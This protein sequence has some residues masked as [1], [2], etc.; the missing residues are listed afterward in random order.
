MKKLLFILGGIILV[1]LLGRF[2]WGYYQVKSNATAINEPSTSVVA[3]NI[4]PNTTYNNL[5]EY[6]KTLVQRYLK[7]YPEFSTGIAYDTPGEKPEDHLMVKYYDEKTALLGEVGFKGMTLSIYDINTLEK[8]SKNVFYR[9]Y[10]DFKEYIFHVSNDNISYY[11]K[12]ATDF[13]L[14]PNSSLVSKKE[15]YISTSGASG[16]EG[17][18]IFDEITKTLTVSVFDPAFTNNGVSTKKIR[19]VKFIL[20]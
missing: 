7:K 15:T 2:G 18:I 13:Y 17:D 4:L 10:V 6:E 9:N 8:I 12:G 5:T 16:E 3:E 14:I 20:N 19:T 1:T 11:K